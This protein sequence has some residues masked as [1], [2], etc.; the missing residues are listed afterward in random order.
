M[1]DLP[2]AEGPLPARSFGEAL[3][4]MRVR[5]RQVLASRQLPELGRVRLELHARADGADARYAFTVE[6]VDDSDPL[7]L[8]GGTPSGLLDPGDLFLFARR[9]ERELEDGTLGAAAGVRDLLLAAEAVEDIVKFVPVGET[10][11]PVAAFRTAATRWLYN[12]D[13][14]AFSRDR[15]ISYA[16]ELRSRAVAGQ[17]DS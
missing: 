13:R 8:G 11:V 6:R 7:Y 12:R 1:D 2:L 3:L 14:T 17:G 10:T 15:L 4:Y 5:G 9:I 16:A